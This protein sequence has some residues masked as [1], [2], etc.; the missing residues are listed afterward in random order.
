[1]EQKNVNPPVPSPDE[2]LAAFRANPRDARLALFLGVQLEDA[3]REEEAI[4]VWS[5]G[6]DADPALRMVKDNPQVHPR[7]REHSERAD[8]AIRR[9]FTGLHQRALAEFAAEGGEDI[10]RVRAG[11]W[12][13]THDAPFEFGTAMQE[14]MIFYMPGLP[15]APAT[16]RERLPWAAALEEHW[17]EIRSEYERAARDLSVMTPYVPANLQAAEWQKLSGTLDWSAIYLFKESRRGE[18][19]D[20]FPATLAALEQAD[21]V[22]V[23]GVPMEAFFSRLVPGAHIPPH[24]GL[25]NT[26]LT[27]HLPLIVPDDCAIRVGE[28]EYR[29]R[30]GEILAFDDSF[31]HEAWNRSDSDRVVLIFETHHP[32]LSPAERRA[33]EHAYSVRQRWLDGREKL[34]GWR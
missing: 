33:V 12:S 17:H 14:P 28:E 5:L 6:D 4:A 13:L 23:D 16:D 26:R 1:M 31:E 2:L 21:L 30:E 11:I 10:G 22:R 20:R 18:H 24:H 7:M 9:F 3:G 8:A 34:L 25:T 15:A 29:W 19:A 32:D 27:V